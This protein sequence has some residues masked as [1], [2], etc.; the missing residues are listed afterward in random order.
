[1][2]ALTVVCLK[3]HKPPHIYLAEFLSKVILNILLE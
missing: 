2:L 3:E 1:M